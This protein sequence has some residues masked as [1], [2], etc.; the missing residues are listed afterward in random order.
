[1]KST[2]KIEL[3]KA[4]QNKLFWITLLIAGIIAT[5]SAIYNI[6]VMQEEKQY[7]YA[8]AV[9][10][11]GVE[12]IN[13]NAPLY[14]LFNHWICEDFSS[15][16]ST[17][18]FMLFPIF[19]V[20][21]YG[22]SLFSEQKSGYIKNVVTRVSKRNYF[23]SKYI[24]TFLSGGAI[25]SIPVIFN[26]LLV[27]MFVPAVKPDVFYDIGWTVRTNSMFSE[28]FYTRPFLYVFLRIL[29]VFLF[30]GAM[31]TISYALAFFIRNR[32][33]VILLPFLGVLA[34]HFGQYLLRDASSELSPIYLLG[35]YGFNTKMLWA[36]ILELEV[37]LVPTFL[38]A[39][40]KGGKDDVF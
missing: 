32:F 22:W 4:F 12:S 15:L 27:S 7:Y 37:I 34:L 10:Q 28:C 16:S 35:G 18:F 13:P 36:V 5:L 23:L 40:L 2:L 3:K 14:S 26:F 33:A 21:G 8:N 39:L 24:A 20:L 9:A 11:F 17:M 31:A 38:L 30:S 25:V 29:V 6:Q 19:A 1:M